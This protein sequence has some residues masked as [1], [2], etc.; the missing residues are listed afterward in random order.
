MTIS[1]T[2][3][4]SNQDKYFDLAETET[5]IIRRRNGRRCHLN[6][7]PS[8]NENLPWVT[9]EEQANIDQALKD[10]ENGLGHS[11]RPDETPEQFLERVL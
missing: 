5:I 11:M 10:Y 1:E 2:E 7:A 4:S 6:A 8:D 9:P 3:F